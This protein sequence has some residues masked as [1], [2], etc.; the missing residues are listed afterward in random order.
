M[1]SAQLVRARKRVE[2]QHHHVEN[3]KH[4]ENRKHVEV[5]DSAI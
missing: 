5:Y 4:A 3:L 2:E 1:A